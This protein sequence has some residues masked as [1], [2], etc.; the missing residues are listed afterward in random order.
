MGAELHIDLGREVRVKEGD[1]SLLGA[2][3]QRYQEPLVLVPDPKVGEDG[4]I[5]TLHQGEVAVQKGAFLGPKLAQLLEEGQDGPLL[6][7]LR[8]EK[9]KQE[10]GV[11]NYN[12][13]LAS[14]HP[15]S[16]RRQAAFCN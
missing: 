15:V 1:G 4:G 8:L 9:K 7:L 10:G 5:R 2:E 3:V 12:I 16:P 13:F 14:S 6:A 11:G